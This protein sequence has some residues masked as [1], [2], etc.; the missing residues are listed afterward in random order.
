MKKLFKLSLLFVFLLSLSAFTDV[1]TAETHGKLKNAVSSSYDSIGNFI[2]D[3]E[4]GNV[5][6][7]IANC[8]ADF[9]FCK[10]NSDPP[11]LTCRLA[12]VEC[13]CKCPS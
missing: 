8:Y 3:M 13:L 6:P 5:N 7:C 10:L 12:L 4:N 1:P 11:F 9:N 2:L